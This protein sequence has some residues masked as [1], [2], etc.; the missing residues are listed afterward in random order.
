MIG[1]TVVGDTDGGIIEWRVGLVELM[2]NW[3][4]GAVSSSSTEDDV[5]VGLSVT[6]IEVSCFVGLAVTGIPV[7]GCID[8][9]AVNTTGIRVGCVD[10]L[11]VTRRTLGFVVGTSV[12]PSHHMR[13]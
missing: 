12:A 6:G 8:G 11:S 4:G 9:L 3:L 1:D 13:S 10:G 2:G 5:L 7:V